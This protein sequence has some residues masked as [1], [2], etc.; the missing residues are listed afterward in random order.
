MISVS[1]AAGNGRRID[2]HDG[3]PGPQPANQIGTLRQTL[4]RI[5]GTAGAPEWTGWA[6]LCPPI[7]PPLPEPDSADAI[8]SCSWG[9][10]GG[11]SQSKP[12]AACWGV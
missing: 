1:T 11:R 3:S 6:S 8:L 12:F 7:D 4:R 5:Y 10:S 9:W 2:S